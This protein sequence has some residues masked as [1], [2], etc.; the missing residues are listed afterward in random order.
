MYCELYMLKLKV[1]IDTFNQTD[2]E[3]NGIVCV[4]M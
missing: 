2:G 3:I 4:N 1:T